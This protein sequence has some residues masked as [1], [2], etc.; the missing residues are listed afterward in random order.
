MEGND[1]DEEQVLSVPRP[2]RNKRHP[3]PSCPGLQH[4]SDGAPPP[5]FS[6]PDLVTH[7]RAEHVRFDDLPDKPGDQGNDYLFPNP[8]VF[9]WLEFHSFEFFQ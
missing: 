8:D 3:C 9:E 5:I 7:V 2:S 4:E 6:V 1:D